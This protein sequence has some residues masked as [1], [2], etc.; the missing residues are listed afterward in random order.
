MAF[1]LL[2]CLVFPSGFLHPMDGDGAPPVPENRVAPSACLRGRQGRVFGPLPKRCG[3]GGCGWLVW[4]GE[5][6]PKGE[7]G[8]SPFRSESPQRLSIANSPDG[9]REEA[10]FWSGGKSVRGHICDLDSGRGN[11]RSRPGLGQGERQAILEGT[12]CL[13]D[14]CFGNTSPTPLSGGVLSVRP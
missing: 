9:G 11:F 5:A 12:I 3:A 13:C 7:R 6:S 4:Y 1:L 2:W 10:A 8:G 14:P